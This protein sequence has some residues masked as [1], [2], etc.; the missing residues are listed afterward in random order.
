MST[1]STSLRKNMNKSEWD[2]KREATADQRARNRRLSLLDRLERSDNSS[3]R[4]R[5]FDKAVSEMR[6]F[7][8]RCKEVEQDLEMSGR[9]AQ[10]TTPSSAITSTKP[11]QVEWVRLI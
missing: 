11:W 9:V 2:M 5:D 8:E 10:R 3:H 6:S 4:E 7:K 1:L